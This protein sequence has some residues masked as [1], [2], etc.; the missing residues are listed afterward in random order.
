RGR[1][2]GD[3]ALRGP[4][5]EG[6]ALVGPPGAGKWTLA[7]LVA[8]LYDP[9]E[10]RVAYGD[11]D[12]RDA[13]MRSLRQRIVVV[14]QEGFLFSG[15]IRDNVAVGRLSASAADVEEALRVIGAYERFARL[16]EGLDTEVHE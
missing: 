4:P 7:N 14:P 9:T 6:V 1:V 11:V 10:G 2:L 5:G 8:R 3:G 12:L 16:P 15:S 13:T